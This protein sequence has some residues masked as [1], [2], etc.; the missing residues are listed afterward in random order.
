M[1]QDMCQGSVLL[2]KEELPTTSE[3]VYEELSYMEIEWFKE[4]WKDCLL[5]TFPVCW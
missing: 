1:D 2:F 3:T 5:L 4:K